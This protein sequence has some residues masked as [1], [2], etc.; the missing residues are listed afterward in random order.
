MPTHRVHILIHV[1]YMYLYMYQQFRVQKYRVMGVTADPPPAVAALCVRVANRR[2]LR[3]QAVSVCRSRG[4]SD[5]KRVI[6]LHHF[7]VQRG[8][9]GRLVTKTTSIPL[10]GI[11]PW[12]IIPWY[13]LS[14]TWYH[15]TRRNGHGSYTVTSV[16]T[17]YVV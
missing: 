16:S 11:V 15:D 1:P 10:Y 13:K 3:G 17:A 6:A 9:R 8:T 4:T 12:Y 14:V 5:W 2:C 7:G